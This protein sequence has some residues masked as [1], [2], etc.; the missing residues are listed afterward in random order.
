M[1]PITRRTLRTITSKRTTILSVLGAVVLLLAGG[2]AKHPLVEWAGTTP[3][4]AD[5]IVS[6]AKMVLTAAAAAGFS[7]VRRPEKS[8]AP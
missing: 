3:E 2:E 4:R 8:E 7:P 6:F 1:K 5:S